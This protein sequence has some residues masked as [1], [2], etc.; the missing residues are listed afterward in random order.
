MNVGDFVIGGNVHFGQLV[1]VLVVA[2]PHLEAGDLEIAHVR[3][4]NR[5]VQAVFLFEGKDAGV[6][7]A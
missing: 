4:I 7:V 6:V 3:D 5:H 2:G 1:K